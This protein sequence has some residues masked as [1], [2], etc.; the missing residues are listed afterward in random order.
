PRNTIAPYGFA[1]SFTGML[2]VFAFGALGKPATLV[3][4][5]FAVIAVL[6]LPGLLLSL[7][8]L[9]WRPRRLAGWGVAL[10]L[11]GSLNLAA[12]AF[13]LRWF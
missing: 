1:L 2:A 7:V 3:S 11:F 6:S 5:C 4:T 9:W 13:S 10:G 8:A 12:I